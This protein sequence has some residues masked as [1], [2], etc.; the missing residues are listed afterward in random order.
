MSKSRRNGVPFSAWISRNMHILLKKQARAN[1]STL[2]Q[3]ITIA[4]NH[5][6]EH[7]RLGFGINFMKK[8]S[9]HMMKNRTKID[10]SITADDMVWQCI[11]NGAK[12]LESQSL[13]FTA[14]T[15]SEKK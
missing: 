7:V 10:T 8:T 6:F 13:E 4:L 12:I 2:T 1:N 11:L 9:S 3:E 15:I 5:Y 14:D